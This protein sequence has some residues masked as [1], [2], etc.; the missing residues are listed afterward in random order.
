MDLQP[1]VF[2]FYNI[3]D[4]LAHGTTTTT[5]NMKMDFDLKRYFYYNYSKHKLLVHTFNVTVTNMRH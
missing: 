3:L 4:I 1:F 2:F 5:K